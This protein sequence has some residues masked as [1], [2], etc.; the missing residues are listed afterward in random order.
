MAA[1]TV[2]QKW[3]IARWPS[4]CEVLK[5]LRHVCAIPLQRRVIVLEE[6]PPKTLLCSVLG[7]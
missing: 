4:D 7:A 1:V 6:N 2:P 5:P 3:L